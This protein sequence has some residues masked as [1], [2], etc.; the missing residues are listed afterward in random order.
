MAEQNDDTLQDIH[1]EFTLLVAELLGNFLPLKIPFNV[2]NL[3]G[4]WLL[5]VGQLILVFNA[6]QQFQQNGSGHYYSKYNK[7]VGNPLHQDNSDIYQAGRSACDTQPTVQQLQQEITQLRQRLE[8][9]ES[10]LR[11]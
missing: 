5:L 1:P 6:Q 2:Q 11:S 3:I 4:N 7:D 10:L 8:Q 9:I